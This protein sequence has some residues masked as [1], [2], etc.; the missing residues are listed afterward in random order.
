MAESI[1]N[2]PIRLTGMDHDRDGFSALLCPNCDEWAHLRNIDE[3]G[4]VDCPHC[5]CTLSIDV[6]A[7]KN[8]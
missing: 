2:S 3:E 6:S 4:E 8:L 7:T 5:R 1:A